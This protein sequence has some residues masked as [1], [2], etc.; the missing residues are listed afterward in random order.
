VRDE[1]VFREVEFGDGV[2]S[3]A[4]VESLLRRLEPPHQLL[5]RHG[6]EIKKRFD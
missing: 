4:E 3:A 2:G 1:L 6:A 5:R